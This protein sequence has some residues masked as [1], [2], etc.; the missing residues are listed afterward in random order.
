MAGEHAHNA[1]GGVAVQ[2]NEHGDHFFIQP[3]AVFV[4]VAEI[5][6]FAIGEC[7]PANGAGG[8]PVLVFNVAGD[9]DAARDGV[10]DDFANA[11]ADCCQAAGC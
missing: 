1:V 2:R 11:P 9:N 6:L 10:F 4:G 3:G 7:G 8:W 5:D